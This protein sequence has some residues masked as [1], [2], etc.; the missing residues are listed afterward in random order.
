MS[1]PKTNETSPP[2]ISK[3]RWLQVALWLVV[4]VVFTAAL[5][6]AIWLLQSHFRISLKQYGVFAY[7]I[8]FGVTFLSSCTIVFP[9]PGSALVIAAASIWNPIIIALAAGAGSTLGEITGYYA[10]YLGEKI[11]IDE[12]NPVYQRA[13]KWM[14]RY[15]IWTVLFIA[16]L[17]VVMFDIIGLIAGALRIPLWKFLLVCWAGKTPRAFLEAFIGAGVLPH[18]FPSWFI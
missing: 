11:I 7:L 8:V 12:Q 5:I 3:R 1:N 9:A 4:M 16:A 15:G 2:L 14:N 6:Y 18:F 17:P 10:G 13:V